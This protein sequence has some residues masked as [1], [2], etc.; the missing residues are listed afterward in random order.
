[1]KPTVKTKQQIEGDRFVAFGIS[2]T[3]LIRQENQDSILL[4]VDGHFLLLA[5]G[6]GGHERGEVASFT[7]LQVIQEYLQPD[8]IL[9]EIQEI[10]RVDG[11][12]AKVICFL[13]LVDKGINKANSVLYE[14][15]REEGLERYMGSTVVGLIWVEEDHIVWFNVGDSRLYRLRDSVL[16]CLTI[17]H[18]AYNTWIRNGKE[19]EEPG[20][21]IVTRAVG[22]REGVIPDIKFGKCRKEDIYLLC[23]DGLSDMVT[24]EEIANVLSSEEDVEKIAE[25]L[26]ETAFNAGGV[27]NISVIVS[28]F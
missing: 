6:M 2:D 20:K 16:K 10:T 15:N 25:Q 4:D 26:I 3:G 22:P 27:D 13:S 11:I 1:M 21:N 17:D 14:L 24:D 18:S 23:S 7:S 28:R 19:G 12:P 5:D 9:S 8:K